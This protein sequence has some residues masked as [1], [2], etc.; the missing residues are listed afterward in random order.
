MPKTKKMKKAPKVVKPS[1]VDA[2][3][4]LAGGLYAIADAIESFRGGGRVAQETVPEEECE[5]PGCDAC[6]SACGTSG[7]GSSEDSDGG[8]NA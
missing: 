8:S 4:E 3:L 6:G 7:S 1:M 5:C 2:V